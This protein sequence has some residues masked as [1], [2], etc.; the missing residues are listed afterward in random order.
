[1][2]IIMHSTSVTILVC[3]KWKLRLRG[4]GKGKKGMVQDDD[5]TMLFNKND[6]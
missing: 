4:I 2:P 3:I 1:M 6:V 5:Q